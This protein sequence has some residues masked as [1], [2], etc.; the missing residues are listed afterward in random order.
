MVLVRARPPL[1]S[2][3]LLP[4]LQAVVL[5]VVALAVVVYDLWAGGSAIEDQLAPELN[6]DVAYADRTHRLHLLRAC[7]SPIVRRGL[8][9]RDLPELRRR[10]GRSRL[11]REVRP[12][13]SAKHLR[14]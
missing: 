1:P 7:E 12:D 9:I 4:L 14:S 3:P 11:G 5:H 6:T 8:R 10:T 2:P 13:G